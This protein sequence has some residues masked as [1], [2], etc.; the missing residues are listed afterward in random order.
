M[1]SR[2]EWT[3]NVSCPGCG[4]MGKIIFS[5]PG[6]SGRDGQDRV[7]RGLSGF[8]TEKVENGFQFRCIDCKRHARL[9]RPN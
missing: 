1:A 8:R 5:G 2:V 4:K 9:T 6:G 3:E 7:E